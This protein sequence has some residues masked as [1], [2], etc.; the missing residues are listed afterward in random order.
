MTDE[1]ELQES[2]NRSEIL[3]LANKSTLTRDSGMWNEL[4]ECFHSDAEFTSS[5]WQGKP[6]DFIKIASKKLEVAR[7][8]GGEQKHLTGNHWIKINGERATAECDQILFVRRPINGIQLDFTTWSRKLFLMTKENGEWK[9]WRRFVIYERD[10]MDPVDPTV[11]PDKYYDRGAL[12]KYPKQ[13][14]HHL[15]RNE[16]KGSKP[17]KNLCIKGTEQEKKV[18][19]EALEWIEGR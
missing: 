13:I 5:W 6:T 7:K 11:S 17:A 19:G 1:K 18:R 10:R 4:A 16:L 15:W 14:C 3:N 9:I 8:E 2:I 12:S